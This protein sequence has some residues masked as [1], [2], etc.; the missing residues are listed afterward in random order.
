MKIGFFLITGVLMCSICSCTGNKEKK[1]AQALLYEQVD[2]ESITGVAR[3][4]PENGLLNIHAGTGGRISKIIALENQHVSEKSPLLALDDAVEKALLEVEESKVPAQNAA[5]EA[6]V[7]NVESV[8]NDLEKARSDLRLNEQLFDVKAVTEQALNDSKVNVEKLAG[9]YAKVL[10]D[11]NQQTGKMQ[12]I[13]AG[14]S[15][16]KA[17]LNERL[18]NA[19][20]AGHVLQWEVHD[21]DYVTQGQ[22]LGQFAPEGSLVAVTEIDELFQ[23]RIKAGMKADVYSQLNGERIATGTVVYVADFLKKKSLFSDENTV[24]DRRVK[25]V[26]VRLDNS[27]KAVINSKV[28]CTIHLK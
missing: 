21:G 15:Y 6:A 27:S 22:K 24:E 20:F 26:K 18:L 10:A 16:R 7:Q 2:I 11:K 8:K 12:E 25:E 14:I 13:K 23:D 17:L 1:A 19:A 28:D 5:I 9:S 3:V 4:E